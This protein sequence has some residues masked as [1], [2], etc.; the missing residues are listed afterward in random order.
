MTRLLAVLQGKGSGMVGTGSGHDRRTVERS[1]RVG[2]L[3]FLALAGALV[4]PNQAAAS[5]TVIAG[6]FK[7]TMMN[8]NVE[9]Q[10]GVDYEYG[11]DSTSGVDEGNRLRIMTSEQVIVRMKDGI[12]APAT[13]D[14]I[15]IDPGAGKTADVSL[16]GIK[17]SY[18][19]KRKN[20]GS[21]IVYGKSPL[22]I[23][24]GSVK[25]CLLPDA[26][27]QLTSLSKG[28][29]YAGAALRVNAGS[30]LRVEDRGSL[31]VK[32]NG[33]AYSNAD[34]ACIGGNPQEQSG[35]VEIA[36]GTVVLEVSSHGSIDGAALGSGQAGS[37]EGITISGGKLS[38]VMSAVNVSGAGIGS[39]AGASSCPVR[40]IGGEIDV[41]SEASSYHR[42]AAI[43]GGDY[44][45]ADVSISG[46]SVK[47]ARSGGLSV[48]GDTIGAGRGV[49][50]AYENELSI[51]GGKFANANIQD[52]TV[53]GAK[54][55]DGYIVRMN[56]G[57][58]K[59]AYPYLVTNA[60]GGFKVTGGTLGT[61]YEYGLD[62]NAEDGYR[63]LVKTSTPLTIGMA[64][65]VI[66]T[67]D[68]VVIDPGAD[69]K[70]DVTLDGVK[71]SYAS[72]AEVGKSPID[73]AS[74]EATLKLADGSE[75][76]ITSSAGESHI[77]EG[78]LKYAG[79]ALHIANGVALRVKG[80]GSLTARLED[81]YNFGLKAAGIGGNP[82]E[83]AGLVEIED[84][85]VKVLSSVQ[86]SK[87]EGA[88]IGAGKDGTCAGVTISGGTVTA[89]AE[90]P[91]IDA[92]GIGSGASSAAGKSSCP[93]RI[94]G[95][96]VSV[97][98]KA[99]GPNQGAAIGGGFQSNSD[100]IISGGAVKVEHSGKDGTGSKIGAGTGAEK[101]TNS[102]TIAGGKFA[103]KDAS[104]K[105]NKV[106][107]AKIS[108]GYALQENSGSD[109]D[110]Y[111]FEVINPTGDFAVS[112]GKLGEDYTYK[113]NVL[114]VKTEKALTIGMSVFADDAFT[115]DNVLEPSKEVKNGTKTDRIVIDPGASKTANVT[116]DGAAIDMSGTYGAAA[117]STASGK[118]NVTLAE[119]STN[120]LLGGGDAAGLSVG[121]GGIE[122]NGAGSLYAAGDNGGAGIGSGEGETAGDIAIAASTTGTIFALGGL[123]GAGIGSGSSGHMGDISIAG[124]TVHARGRVNGAGIGTGMNGSAGIISISNGEV[125]ARAAEGG[126]AIGTGDGSGGGAGSPVEKIVLSGGRIN[127]YAMS[128]S[129]AVIGSERGGT[130]G[131][132]IEIS[133]GFISADRESKNT[134]KPIG[135]GDGAEPVDVTIT[136]G[137]FADGEVSDSGAGNVYGVVP[138]SGYAVTATG[139]TT[140]LVAPYTVGDFTVT[141]GE[142]KKDYAYA[143]HILTVK[144]EAKLTIGMAETAQADIAY[145]DAGGKPQ[146]AKGT[147]TD[148][149]VI[150]TA[151]GKTAH[152]IL[153]GVAIGPVRAYPAFSTGAGKVDI[154]L[155][156]KTTNVLNADISFA[157]LNVGVGG[158]EISGGGTL[159]AN[160]GSTSGGAGIGSES[161]GTSGDITI[162]SGVVIATGSSSGAGIGSGG[163]GSVGDITVKGGSVT[164]TGGRSGAG[165]GSGQH[166]SAG[167][168][169]VMG[170]VVVSRGGDS[171]A[172]VGSGASGKVKDISIADGTLTATASPRGAGIGSGESAT[173]ENISVT[174]G[175]VAAY[176]GMDGAGIGSSVGTYKNP[177]STK[178]ITISG[179]NVTAI[180]GKRAA[181]IGSATDPA[182]V[183]GD[184]TIKGGTVTATGG[185]DGAG[186]GTG[187]GST[188]GAIAISGGTVTATG[189]TGAAGI[190]TGEDGTT[191][192]VSI[193]GGAIKAAAG[194]G[195]SAIGTG[196]RAEAP[197]TVTITGGVFADGAVD[198]EGSGN[199]YGVVPAAGYA[200]E[201]NTAAD[202][203]E[204][205]PFRVA[206]Y[207][208]GDFV[209]TGGEAK[210]DYAFANKVLTVKSETPLTIG[211]ADTAKADISYTDADGN[212]KTAKG[213]STDRIVTKVGEAQTAHVTLDG[214][215]IDRGDKSQSA[216]DSMQGALELTLGQGSDSIL[217]SDISYA[218]LSASLQGLAIKGEGDLFAYGGRRAPGI[219]AN[220][221]EQIGSIQVVGG[222]V[223]AIGGEYAA[224]IGGAYSSHV[225]EIS[226]S[227][228]DVVAQGVLSGAGIGTGYGMSYQGRVSEVKSIRISGGNVTAQGGEYAAAIGS[229]Y[230][231]DNGV[232]KGI[233]IS[234][235]AIKATSGGNGATA[236]GAGKGSNP[237]SVTITGGVFADGAAVSRENP[238]GL[239]CG[240]KPAETHA[241]VLNGD[242]AT[243]S[244]YPWT[245]VPY[246]TGDFTVSGGK[247]GVDYMYANYLLT[248][249]TDKPLTISMAE[250]AS[251]K[252][253][254]TD[255][256]GATQMAKGT[257]VGG[258][259]ADP[260]AGK[261]AHITLNGVAIDRSGAIRA[262]VLA[263]GEAKANITLA[264]GTVNVLRGGVGASGINVGSGGLEL[265]GEGMLF[266]EGGYRAPGIGWFDEGNAHVGGDISV[267]GGVITARSGAEAAGI[268]SGAEC[269]I[270][271]ISITG[272]DVLAIAQD[273]GGFNAGAGI[274]S[275]RTGT[276]GDIS[277]SGGTVVARGHSGSAGIGSGD[278]G[279]AGNIFVAGGSVTATGG[280]DAAGIGSSLDGDAGSI[281][282]SDGVAI[283]IG[284]DGGAGIGA[285]YRLDNNAGVA[286]GGTVEKISISGG[287]VTAKGGAY[288]AAIGSG[289]S[290]AESGKSTVS[291]VKNGIE[292]SG[293]AIQA[294]AG[295]NVEGIET[296]SPA[297]AI[298]AGA[299]S[300]KV[301]TTITGG[302]F[303]DT[304]ESAIANNT[305]YGVA[306]GAG[307]AACAN[308]DA[309]T[310]GTYPVM[311]APVPAVTLKTDASTVYGVLTSAVKVSD[312][313]ASVTFGETEVM[314]EELDK[315]GG[316]SYAYRAAD[317]SDDAAWTDGLPVEV[318]TYDLRVTVASRMIAGAQYAAATQKG[319]FTVKRSG[320]S[321]TA[322]TYKGTD[323]AA[324]FTYGD[325]MTVKATTSATG[326]EAADQSL[327][328]RLAFAAPAQRQM[329]LYYDVNGDG[330]LGAREPQI[331]AAVNADANGAYT[332]MY[333]TANQELPVGKDIKL[334]AKFAGDANQ[335]DA[336]AVLTVDIVKKTVAGVVDGVLSKAY[337]GSVDVAVP[338]TVNQDDLVN[339]DD[340]VSASGDGTFDDANA[341]EDKSV[342][343][344]TV[345][346]SGDDADWYDVQA[347][348]SITGTIAQRV[349]EL[350]WSGHQD[351]YVDDGEVVTAAVSNAVT[352]PGSTDPDKV[353][354]TVEDGTAN[355]VGSYTA[356]ATGLTGADAANYQLPT[357]DALTRA[358]TI[359]QSGSTFG[360]SLKALNGEVASTSFAYGDTIAVAGSVKATGAAPEG[361]MVSRLLSLFTRAGQQNVAALFY[362]DVQLVDW[363]TPDAEDGSFKLAYDTT[364]RLVPAG[365]EVAL[366]VKYRGNSD[367]SDI[368]RDITVTLDKA[369]LTP[370]LAHADA[371]V[372][373]GTTDATG[374]RVAL[375]G[376]IGEDEPA[377]TASFAWAAAAA[378]TSTFDAADITLADGAVRWSDFY[379][380]STGELR[381]VAPADGA[382]PTIAQRV[383]TLAGAEVYGK[384]YDV[385]ANATV[386]GLTLE[387][388]VAGEGLA[389]GNGVTASAVLDGVDAGAHTATVTAA[390]AN[391]GVAANYAF[392]DT[393]GNPSRTA[394]CSVPGVVVTPAPLAVTANDVHVAY[395]DA[396][397]AYTVSYAGFKGADGVGS[398]GEG[399]AQALKLSCGYAPYAADAQAGS[400]HAVTVTGPVSVGNYTLTYHAGTLSVGRATAPAARTAALTVSNDVARE[401][402]VDLS[403]ML[404]ALPVGASFGTVTYG[405]G[406]VSLGDYYDAAKAPARIEGTKLVLP[407]QAVDTDVEGRIGTVKISISS[408][409]FA[410]FEAT[411]EVSAVNPLAPAG[412]PSAAVTSLMY[413]DIMPAI[414]GAFTD[415]I[416]GEP[417]AGTLTWDEP[418]KR[419]TAGSHALAWTF[420]PQDA[421]HYLPAT[422]SIAVEVAPRVLK[423]T[424]VGAADKVFDG[425]AIATM[426][427]EPTLTAASAAGGVVTGDQVA[428]LPGSA[429]FADAHAGTGKTVTFTGFTLS[430]T[431]AANYTLAQ[432]DAVAASITPMEL[433]SDAFALAVKPFAYTGSPAEPDVTVRG[434]GGAVLMKGVD[435]T[436]SYA[437]NMAATVDGKRATVTVT[438]MGDYT[439]SATFAFD[440]ARASWTY[441]VI[442]QMLPVYSA[443]SALEVPAAGTGVTRVDG[444]VEQ[445]PGVLTWYADEART[446]KLSADTPLTGGSDGTRTL[447]WTF[448]PDDSAGNAN[449]TADAVEGSMRVVLTAV[450]VG[451]SIVNPDGTITLP[452]DKDAGVIG[453]TVVPAV[454]EGGE[455]LSKPTINDDGSATLPDGGSYTPP[456]G[457]VGEDG[458]AGPAEV[459]EGG[460]VHPDGTVTD[461]DGNVMWRPAEEKPAP[462]PEPE[463]EP[464]PNPT[465]DP[466]PTPNPEPNPAPTPKP[467]PAPN[468][469]PAP[470]PQDKQPVSD[471]LP[472]AGDTALLPVFPTGVAA[473]VCLILGIILRKRNK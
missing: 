85:T 398:L 192:G 33:G 35:R 417:V 410:D 310:S 312:I 267:T 75:N 36:G 65:G 463:P 238:W 343:V 9:P 138:E 261:T 438:A 328:Q 423:V 305:V 374:G 84:G 269:R 217:K 86:Y 117:L 387:N 301:A 346:V 386:T 395:G 319:A 435:Y 430:G 282:I 404:P 245:V 40:I 226:I 178:S 59:E 304:D 119:G 259:F 470:K 190:G 183:V 191:K 229:G 3:L 38:V 454:P 54:V 401:M 446:R 12:D 30:S 283:A 170:G 314:G 429:S 354:V 469:T 92:A 361:G 174:D 411:I 392:A 48:A 189:G 147:K 101:A 414:S 58:D 164:A 424:G 223:V 367:R 63:L 50:G 212:A 162:T 303:A 378:G 198:S 72:T 151:E 262:S 240:A 250:T 23:A 153:D 78:S 136:G 266:A 134:V 299:G 187:N 458:S 451:G 426:T 107:G 20:T 44:S 207:A 257:A 372:Y 389:L 448:T 407:I 45:N 248:V 400:T 11:P 332:M 428:L 93:V 391:D 452:V 110:E 371:K 406:D 333:N 260:G 56:T 408:A 208:T 145:V 10:A 1:L 25:L 288:A 253:V 464:E 443:I 436:L 324:D 247:L 95:G 450:S 271:N 433:G 273:G 340:E 7:L 456:A 74:G 370:T 329:A 215:V 60:T 156:K 171:A 358:Y 13:S 98:S 355:K 182:T 179:G 114:T 321:V 341:G 300:A 89:T 81:Q 154:T 157:G 289:L 306:P 427:G 380:L 239:V 28:T 159:V 66:S 369:V 291:E 326:A 297:Q 194:E 316:I 123:N 67:P 143:D 381:G 17:I 21:P 307:Y 290:W 69:S 96:T 385:S 137:E 144:T 135:A 218:G 236:I 203:K 206:P 149:I 169:A 211:M 104:I 278:G 339:A 227:G 275:G 106:Y 197:V 335:A 298:G 83:S 8:D 318:G 292:I 61:D 97:S 166:G 415:P 180:G 465:P 327:A 255:R 403:A 363:V 237:V 350:T 42:G 221:E 399:F 231:Y 349:A 127:A 158:V 224:G 88:V 205:H 272:G 313:V 102:L 175:V 230:M 214:V 377:V 64:E 37:S 268:G 382:A 280:N 348:E 18:T 256:N 103:D 148:R 22:D 246:T 94:T 440:I 293:G 70:A 437:D 449:Y 309:A 202:T 294:T 467:D 184:I 120:V 353:F 111:P 99:T 308:G 331:S 32:M 439:G 201:N 31:R 80:S 241:A 130:V 200:V 186:I 360:D 172:A 441:A 254:Y 5:D 375:A 445:V 139:N 442:N 459:P 73:I 118:A 418:G 462:E 16:E 336:Q 55:A 390:L 388:V 330:V 113:N 27:S 264:K 461:K 345:A 379:Q 6:D 91:N 347:P 232:T 274:G 122:L 222:H 115:Y 132:G 204:D 413:G 365:G 109:K 422:G 233:E 466:E 337:D 129:S 141:G 258:I 359:G 2:A 126:A 188:V 77:G 34:S 302:V 167:N 43:G 453:G 323:E 351:R 295:G 46:G 41:K 82:G 15:T 168:I 210:K 277:I 177:I 279:H 447:W 181:G 163:D 357:G 311:V 431:D 195:A 284:G 234:G 161:Y 460:T 457:T 425:S 68:R 412:M 112:G 252:I 402:T 338:L 133:G 216:L 270:G 472:Q 384:E 24:S 47:I 220:D 76:E 116:L 173:A 383:V 26:E 39:G 14:R 320:S 155:A 79:T 71:I 286:S 409:N 152:V 249:L 325:I 421:V 315:L 53:Y 131:Q 471:K 49:P 265:G 344:D 420:T 368:Q 124:G 373:D 356:R 142:A 396:T 105:N 108:N 281:S 235:G 29:C 225:G 394:T 455:T 213:T 150:D 90:A 405:V 317:A 57:S 176:G 228:G 196:T 52:G 121:A 322:A 432:P 193:S 434:V 393:D 51:T 19:S 62:S 287:T 444:A 165:I 4:M 419:L 160:G 87:I 125:N 243:K 285:G 100:V 334:I 242:E 352:R 219:G 146:T 209:V 416:T 128:Y 362:G 244:D 263:T 342:T 199:V 468:P 276:A 185:N 140:Y 296:L 251:A 376:A 473:A 366:T 397:P 364:K